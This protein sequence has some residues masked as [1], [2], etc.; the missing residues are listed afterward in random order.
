MTVVERVR[1]AQPCGSRNSYEFRSGGSAVDGWSGIG[2]NSGATAMERV[3][4]A[5]PCGSRIATAVLPAF[6]GKGYVMRLS[7]TMGL[8]GEVARELEGKK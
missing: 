8:A 4:G 6:D 1:G 5:Q 3:R 7:E 2:D